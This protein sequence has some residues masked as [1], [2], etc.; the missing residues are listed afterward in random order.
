MKTYLLIW[1]LILS[2][3]W[4]YAANA[5]SW[6]I[7]HISPVV[8]GLIIREFFDM[9]S[10]ESRLNVSIWGL[11]ALFVATAAA[12]IVNILIGALADTNHRFRMSALLRRNVL[13][14]MLATPKS[15]RDVS[16]G[17]TVNILE[18]DGKQVEDAIS[19]SVDTMGMTGFAIVSAIILVGISP[20]LTLL[21]FFP[22]IAV[23]V[24][25]QAA[26]DRL[27]KYRRESRKATALFTEAIGEAF[28]SVQAI[29][30]AG[31]EDRVTAHLRGLG[32]KR[33]DA[34]LKDKL[35]SQVLDS[36]FENASK[37]GIGIILL[38]A[39]GMIQSGELS[40]GDFALFVYYIEFVTDFAAFIGYFTVHYKQAGVALGRLGGLMFKPEEL[41][42]HGLLYL[43][44][45]PPEVTDE[46]ISDDERLV[47]LKVS[48]LTARYP[49]SEN[50][51]K[52][53]SFELDRGAFTVIAGR[54]GSGK[55]T[56]VRALLG[57]IPAESGSVYWNGH[58]VE[59]LRS[60][61][62]P[63]RSA[64]APQVP[65][66]FSDTLRD[67]IMLGIRE[68]DADLMGAVRAAALE[69]DLQDLEKGLDTVVG[70]KGAKLSGGQQQRV[71]VAR[72]LVRRA[73]LM[74]FDDVSSALDVE[75]ERQLWVALANKPQFTFL[76]ISNRKGVILGADKVLVMEGGRIIAQG[77]PSSLS[78]TSA[79][80]RAILEEAK[81][82]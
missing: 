57:F 22:L 31:A 60:F 23:M 55:T 63:P 46:D 75:T 30:V 1:R 49:D 40:V 15:A 2:R 20:K 33:R 27:E 51:I 12:R 71:A 68:G 25:S 54:I 77:D 34:M 17:E 10:G 72:M 5:V 24:V 74:I 62:S 79:E 45:D 53:A 80:L 4:L 14:S 48:G 56:L 6:I 18:E 37:V 61:F 13:E 35:L 81:G 26:S 28:G 11:M 19:W 8:P 41:V 32:D 69:E 42:K 43:S 73:E 65:H 3:P 52:D 64:Y 78:E 82:A 47:N 50:G 44:G 16:P 21:V 38:I 39:A 29:K 76:V 58:K 36:V 7:I 66:L 59:D 67:N 9:L 70:P